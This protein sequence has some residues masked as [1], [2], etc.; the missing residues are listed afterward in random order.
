[1]GFNKIKTL[2]IVTLISSTVITT[3]TFGS[4]MGQLQNKQDDIQ[5]NINA[6]N[7]KIDS[8][9]ASIEQINTQI[10]QLD[11]ELSVAMNELNTINKKL[12][13]VTAQLN[14]AED[15]LIEA[16]RQKEEQNDTLQKRVRYMYEYGNVSY[17]DTLVNAKSFS[18]LINRIE[19]L[20]TI[21]E[22]DVNLYDTLAKK[23]AEIQTLT[24]T[25]K[26]SKA[27]V[28]VLQKSATEKKDE[29]QASVDQK[30]ALNQ[31]IESDIQ[32]LENQLDELDK[33][34][35]DVE[36]MIQAE[37]R[38][39]QELAAQNNSS[40]N[41]TYT[42]GKLMWPSDTTR[43]TSNFGYRIHPI[44]GVR[45]L[46]AGVDVGVSVGTKVYAAESGTVITAGWVQGYGNCVIIMHDNGLTTLYAHLSSYNV[47]N[48]QRVSRGDTIA[49]SGNS[50]NSTGPH[51]HF[52]VRLNGT[53]VDPMGYVQ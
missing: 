32:L 21:H 34:N 52:E 42:G 40:I 14:K 30:E 35:K 2:V 5:K 13:D 8:K 49:Y 3:T 29:L 11:K 50:G 31:K 20:N 12:E 7:D 23:E 36:N 47:S 38:R 6:T 43:I 1:M 24:E 10:E 22:Y 4:S 16:T 28:E 15:D 45:K 17:F 41:T 18:D 46:H 48:G 51:L 19:Y 39:Q 27:E 33:A 25:I 53:V 37:I 44:T 26:S 9:K